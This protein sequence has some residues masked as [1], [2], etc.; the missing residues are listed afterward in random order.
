LKKLPNQWDFI[1]SP[2]YTSLE[3][4]YENKELRGDKKN[5]KLF[6]G[7]PMGTRNNFDEKKT[8]DKNLMRLS[9]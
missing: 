3:V 7:M 6:L 8:G 4:D 5:S 2:V 1:N 9:L